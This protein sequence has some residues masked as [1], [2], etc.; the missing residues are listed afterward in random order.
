MD[1]YSVKKIE[2]TIELSRLLNKKTNFYRSFHWSYVYKQYHIYD[3]ACIYWEK[4]RGLNIRFRGQGIEDI[5]GIDMDNN[6]QDFFFFK[7]EVI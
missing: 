6:C 5:Y 4:N 3:Y 1:I 7:R 2:N